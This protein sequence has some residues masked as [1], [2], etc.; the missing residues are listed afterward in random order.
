M[1]HVIFII[2]IL[3]E[4]LMHIFFSLKKNI[5]KNIKKKKIGGVWLFVRGKENRFKKTIQ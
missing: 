1:C 2:I 5:K 3:V 4:Y